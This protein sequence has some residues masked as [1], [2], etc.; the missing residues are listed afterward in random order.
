MSTYVYTNMHMCMSSKT[1]TTDVGTG[2][3]KTVR[4][5]VSREKIGAPDDSYAND[6][7]WTY[8]NEEV[9]GFWE[10]STALNSFVRILDMRCYGCWK[11]VTKDSV[12]CKTCQVV[13]YCSASCRCARICT[14]T[15]THTHTHIST[16]LQKNRIHYSPSSMCIYSALARVWCVF[17]TFG[18]Q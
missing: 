2:K 1:N 5:D 6:E 15:H 7:W 3:S 9:A 12:R 11:G 13:T 14:H 4:M 18:F 10:W 16:S 17:T 8:A